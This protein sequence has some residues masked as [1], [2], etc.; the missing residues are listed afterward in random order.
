MAK[1]QN[2]HVEWAF[3]APF[4]KE[5]ADRLD[6]KNRPLKGFSQGNNS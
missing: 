6:R 5:A 2:L 4:D 1:S 3:I